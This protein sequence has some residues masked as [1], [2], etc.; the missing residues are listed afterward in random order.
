MCLKI[1]GMGFILNKGA[2]IRDAWNLLDFIIVVSSLLPLLLGG[3]SS[4]NLSVLRSLRV[5][6]PLRTISSIR[7][8]KVF[9]FDYL[10]ISPLGH[11]I[12]IILSAALNALYS[13]HFI[14]LLIH[15]RN[16]R[17]TTLSRTSQIKMLYR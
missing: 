12:N 7:K 14:F 2:Y 10:I 16:C 3:S 11:P 5:L 17:S 1:I 8:L 4:I 13:S 6:R 15:L 9:K